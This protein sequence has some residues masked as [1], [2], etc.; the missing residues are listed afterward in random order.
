MKKI[1]SV[2]LLLLCLTA[3][4]SANAATLFGLVDTGELFASSDGGV[5]WSVLSTLPVSDAMAIAAGETSSQLYLA[6]GTGLVYHSADGG[7]NWNAT[8]A[9]SAGNVVDMMIH[10]SGDIFLLTATGEIYLSGDDGVSFSAT[11]TLTASN[12]VAL[13]GDEGGGDIRR[14]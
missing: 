11:A 2:C 6:T 14:V 9:V 1:L 7:L 4:V 10:S 12:H 8:G 13:D 3:P 5:S